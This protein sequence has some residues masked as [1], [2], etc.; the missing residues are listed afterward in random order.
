MACSRI[1][2]R[3]VVN[4]I[5]VYNSQ[6]SLEEFFICTT[7]S[8]DIGRGTN[9]SNRSGSAIL[10]RTKAFNRCYDDK[11][12]IV[13]DTGGDYLPESRYKV[14]KEIYVRLIRCIGITEVHNLITS[15]TRT[16]YLNVNVYTK[17]LRNIR[18]LYGCAPPIKLAPPAYKL[19]SKVS[20][21]EQTVVIIH[22]VKT[23]YYRTVEFL[24]GSKKTNGDVVYAS[25]CI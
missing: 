7:H 12:L 21:V 19:G 13:P 14:I 23:A 16:K 17:S 6:I 8:R 24:D 15:R 22:P 11:S 3:P 9:R 10:A 2:I 4:P 20:S 18:N 25:N 5:W 1:N